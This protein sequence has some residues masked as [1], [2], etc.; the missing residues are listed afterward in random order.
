MKRISLYGTLVE[1]RAFQHATL[2]CVVEKNLKLGFFLG[3]KTPY[4]ITFVHNYA[5]VRLR[6][7]CLEVF[8]SLVAFVL[9]C[10]RYYW[11]AVCAKANQ[12]E[13]TWKADIFGS[14]YFGMLKTRGVGVSPSLCLCPFVRSLSYDIV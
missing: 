13:K 8:K 4:V 11:K 12:L 6:A 3:K 2:A 9:E 14:K 7:L 10:N 5:T 1:F